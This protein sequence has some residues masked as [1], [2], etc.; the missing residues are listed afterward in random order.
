M[1]LESFE[2]I[3]SQ[4][5]P[6]TEQVYLH[7]M[8]EPLLHPGFCGIVGICSEKKLPVI[9]TTNGSM[10]DSPAAEALFNP[11]VRQVNI[12]LHSLDSADSVESSRRLDEV[13]K[14]TRRAF[15]LRPDIY[16]NYRLWN[17][18]SPG[19]PLDSGRNNWICRKISESF[20]IEIPSKGHSSGRKGRRLLNRLYLHLDTR[21]EWPEIKGDGEAGTVWKEGFCHG[22]ESQIAVLVD[23]TV[24]PCCLD[25]DG[26]IAL[27][28][29]LSSPLETI[30]SGERASKILSG[31]QS[32]R[33]V[34]KLCQNCS[35][36][37]RFPIS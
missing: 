9:V 32:G 21:F 18:A 37:T 31:F 17:L 15:E 5:V 35:F 12:S 13:L 34:E 20:N 29:C 24:V 28:N 16:I 6:L 36:S 2:R 7:V 14:F 27:G 3:A 11:V 33:R 23:G 10:M 25:R 22:M 4:A 26:V 8:G 19:E 30:V 1:S